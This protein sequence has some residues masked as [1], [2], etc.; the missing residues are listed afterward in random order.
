MKIT[1]SKEYSQ[2]PAGLDQ[3]DQ[4][5][6]GVDHRVRWVAQRCRVTLATAVTL[7]ANA[8]LFSREER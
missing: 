6:L 3:R 1:H 2:L 5:D 4:H 7:A 8:G